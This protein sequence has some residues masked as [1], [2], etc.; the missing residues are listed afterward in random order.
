MPYPK[1]SFW[2]VVPWT[3]VLPALALIALVLGL[4]VFAASLVQAGG[5]TVVTWSQP[6]DCDV[7]TGWELLAAPITTANPN[8]QPPAA[9]VAVSI[10]NT[11][12]PLCGPGM[13]KTVTLA[14]VGPSRFWIRAAV[15]TFKSGESNSVD[16][17]LPLGK[18]G[19]TSV[20]P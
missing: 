6:T 15:N 20:V 5:P 3:L 9:N 19:L 1:P 16:A 14:G 13:T 8:P 12:T 2:S 4:V 10:P 17:S 11:G 18:P 7:V